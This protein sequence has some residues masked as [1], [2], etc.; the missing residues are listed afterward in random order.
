MRCLMRFLD[1]YK[2]KKRPKWMSIIVW[3]LSI[4]DCLNIDKSI[5]TTG[6]SKHKKNKHT[7][8]HTKKHIDTREK[9]T[10]TK[11]IS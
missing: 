3:A 10:W 1:T 11:P 8:T 4:F 9:H 2:L 7:S 5:K 6:L